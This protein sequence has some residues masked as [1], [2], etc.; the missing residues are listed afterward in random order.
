MDKNED[1]G[2]VREGTTLGE[3]QQNG[4]RERDERKEISTIDLLELYFRRMP[5][6][7]LVFNFV[8]QISIQH[9]YILNIQCGEYS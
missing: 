7:I 1:T 3:D 8:Y 6:N 9:L 4:G 5:H 2:Q